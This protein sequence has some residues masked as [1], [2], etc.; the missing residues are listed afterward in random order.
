MTRFGEDVRAVLERDPAA[1]TRTEVVLAYPG[2]HALW[3]YRI[4]HWLWTHH[5]RTLGR[6]FSHLTRFFTG[7][8]I[9][10]AAELGCRVFIDH[11]M[12]VV[13]GE[14]TKIADGCSIYQGAT[15]GG[16]SLEKGKRHPTLEE[17]VVVGAGAKILGPV[18]VGANARI[19]AN[20]V[21]LHDVPPGTVVVGVPGQVVTRRSPD[22]PP[23]SES[24]SDSPDAVGEAV[25]ALI[26][27]VENLERNTVGHIG[28]GPH[29]PDH[30]VWRG[31]DFDHED[32]S[33]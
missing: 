19:G 29:A 8:E 28:S 20:S 14:T 23:V 22:S 9:H 2:L 18:T 24:E 16:T 11:G 5:L 15:L 1:R 31:E 12:G 33:I 25:V 32:F 30:G 13:V 26:N 10:P 7:I 21:V 17:N 6:L 4:G 3:G 27:R